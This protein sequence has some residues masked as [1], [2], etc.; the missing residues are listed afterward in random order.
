MPPAPISAAISYT[1]RRAPDSSAKPTPG[2]AKA[3]RHVR[4]SFACALFADFAFSLRIVPVYTLAPGGE[5]H[6]RVAEMAGAVGRGHRHFPFVGFSKI[7]GHA[8]QIHR[9]LA[10]GLRIE[11]LCQPRGDHAG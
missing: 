1:P 3:G 6:A 11:Q 8:V 5:L 7:A 4:S 10:G 9:Q 2:P